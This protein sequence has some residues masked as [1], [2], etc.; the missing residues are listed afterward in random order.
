[1][2]GD[3]ATK[4]DELEEEGYI[5]KGWASE[6][7]GTFQFD[8]DD[9][10]IIKNIRLYAVWEKEGEYHT[11]NFI[12]EVDPKL[13]TQS[14]ASDATVVRPENPDIK[15]YDLVNLYRESSYQNIYNFSDAVT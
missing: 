9:T 5:F 10:A 15:G 11:V 8:F 7:S 14:F 13:S 2:H 4:P 3:N 1:M 12:L 6:K